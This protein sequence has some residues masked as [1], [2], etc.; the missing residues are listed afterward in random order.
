MAQKWSNSTKIGFQNVSTGS[1]FYFES[2]FKT[3]KDRKT[4]NAVVLKVAKI[5]TCSRRSK[6]RWFQIWEIAQKFSNWTKVGFQTAS[7]G[8]KICF[9][10]I[11]RTWKNQKT[12]TA[13]V[14]KIAKIECYTWLE[15]LSHENYLCNYNFF[16][17]FKSSSWRFFKINL[18]N[19][20][21]L[22]PKTI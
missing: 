2:V 4:A 17:K 1:K 13:V 9:E 8:S 18:K 3:W 19:F 7:T 15:S 20:F 16:S 21:K 14:L 12:S 5:G 6:V 22:L 11:F 10:S